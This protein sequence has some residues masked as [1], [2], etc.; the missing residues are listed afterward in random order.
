M[1]TEDDRRHH[2]A[3]NCLSLDGPA[4][5]P[6]A[7]GVFEQALANG[8]AAIVARDWPEL[9]PSGARPPSSRRLLRSIEKRGERCGEGLVRIGGESDTLEDGAVVNV[10]LLLEALDPI[11]GVRHGRGGRDLVTAELVA[12][13]KALDDHPALHVVADESLEH[14]W[15][16]AHE[17]D[18]NEYDRARSYWRALPAEER[19]RRSEELPSSLQPTEPGDFH[20]GVC[21]CCGSETLMVDG[22]DD[23]GFG[24]VYGTCAACSFVRSDDIVHEEAMD[25][26]LE[27]HRHE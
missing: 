11:G 5:P 10:A 2:Y 26:A 12:A 6:G 14:F 17:F 15:E 25:L 23:F 27:R 18:G 19:R 1:S 21:P 22:I 24:L 20:P 13:L 3:R 7:E 9:L 4:L 8:L 16:H